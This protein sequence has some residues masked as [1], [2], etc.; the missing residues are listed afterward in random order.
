MYYDEIFGISLILWSGNVNSS[1][2]SNIATRY[3]KDGNE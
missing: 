1:Y 2:G 3:S